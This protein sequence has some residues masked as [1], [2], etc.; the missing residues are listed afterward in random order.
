MYLSVD[1]GKKEESNMAYAPETLIS[2][3]CV[4]RTGN[5]LEV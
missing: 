2:F 4:K 5:C 1:S 3:L